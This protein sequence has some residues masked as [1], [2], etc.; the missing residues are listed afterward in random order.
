MNRILGLA[1]ILTLSLAA[2][3]AAP[4]VYTRCSNLNSKIPLEGKHWKFTPAPGLSK[5]FVRSVITS[6]I[7]RCIYSQ[8]WLSL[9]LSNK[10][11]CYFNKPGQK[12]CSNSNPRNCVVYCQ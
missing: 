7:L 11:N 3:N 5:K 6:N 10:K 12:A 2:A 8:T 4:P 1:F 9:T